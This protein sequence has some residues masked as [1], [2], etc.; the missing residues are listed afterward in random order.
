MLLGLTGCDL[1]QPDVDSMLAPPVLSELQTEVNEAL[2]DVVGQDFRL[3]YPTGGSYRSPYIFADLDGDENEEAVVFYTVE[4]EPL[5]YLQ[6]L[7]KTEGR[8]RAGNAC[9]ALM[10]RSSM[11]IFATFPMTVSPTFWW[12]GARQMP[13]VIPCTSIAS[14]ME[15]FLRSSM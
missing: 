15:P 1:Y 14:G 3:C 2:Q 5:I 11:S 9:P 10:E 7:D 8:W 4:D 13:K 6:I 12:V